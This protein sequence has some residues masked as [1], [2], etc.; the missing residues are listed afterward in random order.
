M[1]AVSINKAMRYVLR[2]LS[3]PD[4][5]I[6]KSYKIERS[7]SNLRADKIM[8]P[9]YKRWDQTIYRG[10][11]EINVR[12]Y[13]PKKKHRNIVLLFFHGGGWVK[14]NVDSY[15]NVCK[16][17]AKHTGCKVLSVEY[18]LA[19]ENPFPS[20]LE[21]CYAVTQ[22][23]LEETKFSD[24]TSE[25]IVLIGDSAGGNL[26][27]VVSLLA[28]DRGA[29][30]V[31]NQILIYPATYNDHSQSSPFKS[32]HEN[33]TD[34]LLTSKRICDYMKLYI[35]DDKDI[36]S[37]YF[38]PLLAE[39]LENMPKTLV[40]S[41]EYDPLRDEGEE[42]GKRLKSAGNDVKVYRMKNALHGFF[43]LPSTFSHVKRSYELINKFLDEI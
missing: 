22:K 2:V 10:D 5:D 34:Y 12:I 9:I 41:A 19:P 38:A 18:A 33:G 29:F 32:V 16:S 40:I 42:F 30:K 21:D 43:G 14:E 24:I 13:T 3:Y 1:S 39:N 15:N 8:K 25:D 23:V 11:R 31:N 6:T 17:L 4:V 36:N 28:R 26:A 7:V 20:G 37:P 27:A 35:S